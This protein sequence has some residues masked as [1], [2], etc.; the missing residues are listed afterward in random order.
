MAIKTITV[1]SRYFVQ[2]E[3]DAKAAGILPGHL[4]EIASDGKVQV[5]ANAGQNAARRFAI[6][7]DLQGN[8]IGDAYTISNKVLTRTFMPGDEVLAIV[9]VGQTIVI[10]DFLESAGDGTLQ[11]H[12][13]DSAGAV[14]FPEAVV[15]TALEAKTTTSATGTLRI[16]AEII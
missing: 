8:E 4:V 6:E 1:S 11:K 14:E 16:V 13:A 10:G 2:K 5:H 15:A 12:T 9:P 3:Y 7:D